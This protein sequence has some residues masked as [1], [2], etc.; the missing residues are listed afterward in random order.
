MKL[1][2]AWARTIVLLAAALAASCSLPRIVVL[3]DPLSAEEHLNLGVAYERRGEPE[4][5]LAEY[6]K[7]SATLP[8][9]LLYMGNVY[10]Q[11]GE[12]E[13]ASRCYR[14][15]ISALP[16]LAEAYNNLAWLYYTQGTRLDEAEALSLRALALQPGNEV[17]EDT[18]EKIRQRR[19]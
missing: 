19:R 5:A 16:D 11:K 8:R 3:Q 14:E 7:A 6:R 2:T 18:L 4:Q 17:F 9:A 12:Y 10:F 1:C 13:E 15:A